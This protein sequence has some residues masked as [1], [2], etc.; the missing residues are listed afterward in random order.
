[1]KKHGEFSIGKN[2]WI[3]KKL[4]FVE[5]FGFYRDTGEREKCF[6]KL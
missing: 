4:G 2:Y 1:M 3:L 5:Q 6:R